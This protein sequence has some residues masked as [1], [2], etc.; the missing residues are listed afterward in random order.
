MSNLIRNFILN[1]INF[2]VQH[3]LI[4]NFNEKNDKFKIIKF[5]LYYKNCDNFEN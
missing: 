5:N 3:L 1:E 4:Y 2:I